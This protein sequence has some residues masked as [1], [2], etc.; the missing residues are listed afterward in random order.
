[1]ARKPI[2]GLLD[3]QPNLS[4]VQAQPAAVELLGAPISR[5][6][7]EDAVAAIEVFIENR[8][9]RQVAT[10]N[11]D[12]LRI[13]GKQPDFAETLRRADLAVADG[14]PLVWASKLAGSPV[15][16]RVAGIDLVDDLCAR[17]STLG[18]SVFLLG[19]APGVAQ[20]ASTTLLER[21]PGLRIAGVY[22][23]PIADWDELEDKRIRN[24]IA[25]SGADILLVALGAPRQD[26]WIAAN[27][28]RLG[29]PVSIGVGCTFDVLAGDTARAPRWMQRVG[30][31]WAFRLITEPKRL[32]RRY[33][34][35]LPTFGRLMLSAARTRFSASDIQVAQG[36]AR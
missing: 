15:P 28:D 16:H 26:L 7:R 10:V 32:W 11:L 1:M 9:P 18:W 14:M 4:L 30:L 36:G 33:L 2:I 24:R 5:L 8:I 31:E 25:S 19:A 20:A 3:H 34:G 17:G 6:G 12:F 13:A 29:V 35:G 27:K 23:P 22:S 21:Y